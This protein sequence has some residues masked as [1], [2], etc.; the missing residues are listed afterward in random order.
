M[1]RFSE[2]MPRIEE[3]DYDLGPQRDPATGPGGYM[4]E[5][6]DGPRVWFSG[7]M[8]NWKARKIDTDG[9]FSASEWVMQEGF[10][11]PPHR[12]E[13]EAEGMYVLEGKAEFTVG[14][15]TF[16]AV[17]GSF[18][19]IPRDTVHSI[20]GLTPSVRIF[21]IIAPGGY[22]RFFEELGEPARW[23]G[24]PGDATEG[25]EATPAEMMEVGDRY[26]WRP[27]QKDQA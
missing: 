10:F 1:S 9:L 23:Y 12:H 3:M 16:V 26:A 19:M 15:D 21:L 24:V 14:G 20:R 4:L 2:G 11:V 25:R 17:P 18:V 27:G 13:Y 8:I 5:P 22:E 7:G 6:T